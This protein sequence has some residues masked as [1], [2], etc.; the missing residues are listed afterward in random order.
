MSVFIN[1][2]HVRRPRHVGFLHFRHNECKNSS[3]AVYF[4]SLTS[5]NLTVDII[6]GTFEWRVPPISS[7]TQLWHLKIHETYVIT[8]AHL[9]MLRNILS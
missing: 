6:C 9:R 7:L 3:P 1:P 2:T 4:H 8:Y 5:C